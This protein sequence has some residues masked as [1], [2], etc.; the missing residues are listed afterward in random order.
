ML[1]SLT[2][3]VVDNKWYFIVGAA[4]FL[5]LAIAFGDTGYVNPG[6]LK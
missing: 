1:K 6:D 2:T 5:V 4:V 3:F